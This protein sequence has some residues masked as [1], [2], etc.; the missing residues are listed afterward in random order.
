V[1]VIQCAPVR[2]THGQGE[3]VGSGRKRVPENGGQGP[4][5]PLLLSK[6]GRLARRAGDCTWRTCGAPHRC[7]PSTRVGVKAQLEGTVSETE[8]NV[9]HSARARVPTQCPCLDLR[10]GARDVRNGVPAGVTSRW[11]DGQMCPH[12]R[13]TREPLPCGAVLEPVGRHSTAGANR[14]EG[15]CRAVRN[16]CGCDSSRVVIT[17]SRQRASTAVRTSKEGG[18]ERTAAADPRALVREHRH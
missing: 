4:E 18:R 12:G 5:N 16:G 17:T 15:Q 9:T 3:V 11:M 13:V 8:R 7:S 2:E 10:T 1:F 6:V 14:I